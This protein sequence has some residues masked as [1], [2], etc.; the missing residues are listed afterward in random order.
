M[1]KQATVENIPPPGLGTEND[2]PCG[3]PA[4]RVKIRDAAAKLFLRFGYGGVSMDAIAAEAGVSKQTVYSHFGT[5]DALFGA[6]IQDKCDELLKPLRSIKIKPQ[7]KSSDPEI[8]LSGIAE[9]FFSLVLSAEGVSHFRAVVAESARFP[10][11]AEAFYRSGPAIAVENLAGY[12]ERMHTEGV[13]HVDDPVG[14]ARLFFGM[15][16]GDTYLR[17]VLGIGGEPGEAERKRLVAQAVRV[18]IA[19]HR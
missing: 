1:V 17:R 10:E 9:N 14:S 18:F 4:K 8:V 15:L 6:I 11:L 7:A 16:R 3:D 2:V 19:A 12:L 5:K 13:L